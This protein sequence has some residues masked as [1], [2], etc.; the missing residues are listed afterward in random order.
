MA[1]R[2]AT[3]QRKYYIE[4]FF[5]RDD[6]DKNRGRLFHRMGNPYQKV[7]ELAHTLPGKPAFIKLI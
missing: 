3:F 2:V 1:W 4:Y 6:P 5:R 7:I